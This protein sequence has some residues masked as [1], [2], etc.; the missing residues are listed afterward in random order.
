M[1]T[2]FVWM[3]VLHFNTNMYSAHTVVID[4]ISS[5]EEC[6]RVQQI[7]KNNDP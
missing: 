3:L 4:N 6:V 5:L 1:N 7:L 2:I